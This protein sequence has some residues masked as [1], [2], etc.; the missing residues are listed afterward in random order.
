MVKGLVNGLSD[1]TGVRGLERPNEGGA[2]PV[3]GRHPELIVS[4]HG[5]AR[6]A[7]QRRVG[8]APMGPW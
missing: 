5:R 2:A 7:H 8:A 1:G 6:T 3:G 4:A